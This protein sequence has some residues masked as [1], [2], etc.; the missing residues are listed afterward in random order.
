MA[1]PDTVAT[2]MDNQRVGSVNCL[3]TWTAGR[4]TWR[5]LTS[6]WTHRGQNPTYFSAGQVQS[7]IGGA[8]PGV[9]ILD[10]VA[11]ALDERFL[12]QCASPKVV[13]ALAER[14][15]QGLPGGRHTQRLFADGT[16]HATHRPDLSFRMVR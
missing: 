13:V 6:A 7:W 5:V 9:P 1:S 16:C 10:S 12:Q 4:P 3:L 15:F 14:R 11:S 2:C 8:N